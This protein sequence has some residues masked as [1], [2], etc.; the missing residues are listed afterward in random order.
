MVS[1]NQT[2]RAIVTKNLYFQ[3][4]GEQIPLQELAAID[5]TGVLLKYPK[6]IQIEESL[7]ES[8]VP[9]QEFAKCCRPMFQNIVSNK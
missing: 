1:W 5:Y 2:N 6:T 8:N 7:L 4:H 9:K 3:A